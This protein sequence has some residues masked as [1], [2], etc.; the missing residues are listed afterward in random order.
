MFAS[1]L[2]Y[3]RRD[4]SM[5]RCC[6]GDHLFVN[7]YNVTSIMPFQYI[8]DWQSTIYLSTFTLTQ[9]LFGGSTTFHSGWIAEDSK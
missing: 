3:A 2:E 7:Y 5:V 4:I 9:N 6:K 8:F 1:A